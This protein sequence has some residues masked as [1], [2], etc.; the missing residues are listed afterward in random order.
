MTKNLPDL[1]IKTGDIVVRQNNP[2]TK[3]EVL[4]IWEVEPYCVSVKGTYNDCLEVTGELRARVKW[5]NNY[6]SS[7]KISSLQKLQ[8]RMSKEVSIPQNDI[9]RLIAQ[10]SNWIDCHKIDSDTYLV[11]RRHKQFHVVGMFVLDGKY[12]ARESEFDNLD[13]AKQKCSALL[14]ELSES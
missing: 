11:L 14:Q 12:Y 6:T 8:D 9:V 13:Y 1:Q 5:S 3:G 4:K 7:V 2:R 10:G